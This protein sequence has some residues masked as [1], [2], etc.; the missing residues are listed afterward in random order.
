MKIYKLILP[1]LAFT[2]AGCPSQGK[3]NA[4]AETETTTEKKGLKDYYEDY[5]PVGV[6]I[7][8]QALKDS[9]IIALITTQFNSMTPENVM[10]MGP[11]HPKE[12]E[13][14]WAAADEIANFAR[15]NN[16]KLR[17]HALVWHNQ[18]GD[19]IFMDED[20]K[21]VSKEVLLERMKTHITEVVTRYKDVIYAWDVVNEAV[22]DKPGEFLRPSP[23]YEILGEDFILKAFEYAHE[24]DPNMKLFY[25]DYSAIRP[26]KRDKIYRLV[27]MV[28]DAGVPIH[29]VG[30]QGHVSIYEPTEQEL[31]EALDKYASLGVEVQITEL[32][33]SVYHKEHQRRDPKPE[34][35]NDDFTPEQEQKQIEQYDML[36]RVFRDYKNTLTGVTF[37]N[38]SDRYSW[39][40]NFPVQGRKNYPLLFDED[41]KP[42]KAYYEVIDFE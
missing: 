3:K 2:L 29:G 41:L 21:Q 25:N 7:Y 22:S 34:D 9:A 42:K 35:E 18:A 15:E 20:G 28:Q 26:E 27:K 10:K 36:F 40:D 37:W 38:I 12:N 19:W 32:D 6:A 16:M 14:N 5:F 4:S 8:P 30:I 33:V 39:L 11:I 13:Y 17:G 24:A 1:L 23:W 31:R